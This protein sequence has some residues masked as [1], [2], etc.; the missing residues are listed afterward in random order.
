MIIYRYAKDYFATEAQVICNT[1]NCRGAYGKGLNLEFAKRFPR[2]IAQHKQYWKEGVVEP[3]GVI[4]TNETGRAT[5]FHCATKDD[6]R[7]PSRYAYVEQCLEE[8]NQRMLDEGYSSIAIPALGCANG[9]LKWAV[10]MPM[11]ES[12]ISHD[13]FETFVYMPM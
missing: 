7:D 4:A 13:R 3:G 1:V 10:V 6:W 9:Q 2:D 12:M 5:I 8:T 11:I